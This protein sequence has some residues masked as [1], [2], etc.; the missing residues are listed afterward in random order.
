MNQCSHTIKKMVIPLMIFLLPGVLFAQGGIGTFRVGNGARLIITGAAKL[1]L[2]DVNFTNDGIFSA[3]NS[4]VIFTGIKTT[5]VGGANFSGFNNFTPNKS[6]NNVKLTQN[7]T[8]TG[9]LTMARGAVVL[10]NFDINLGGTGAIINERNASR[11]MAVG[12]GGKVIATRTFVAN[13]AQNPG[14]IGAELLT[15]S[16]ANTVLTIERNHFP[17]TLANGN[18]SI[19]RTFKIIPPTTPAGL[20]YSLRFFYFDGELNGNDESLLNLYFINADNSIA[21]VGRDASDANTNF[22]LKNSLGQPGHFT[23]ASEA[24]TIPFPDQTLMRPIQPS[25]EKISVQALPN[26]VSDILKIKFSSNAE[27]DIVFSLVDQAGQT[28]QQ[29]KIHCYKGSNIIPWN[30]NNYAA[31]VYYITVENMKKNIKVIKK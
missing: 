29:Q 21:L 7:I 18:G 14:N 12:T 6:N 11:I 8:V 5:T 13:V 10:N 23:L 2:N 3:G 19:E 9:N 1:V 26:P 17:G 28:L 24:S 16:P 25:E 30:M 4:E 15:A 31:G 22:V 20:N 27:K